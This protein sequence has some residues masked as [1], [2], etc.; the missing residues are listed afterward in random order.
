MG[1]CRIHRK[2]NQYFTHF[3]NYLVIYRS[4]SSHTLLFPLEA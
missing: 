3:L 4:Y 2:S 1:M